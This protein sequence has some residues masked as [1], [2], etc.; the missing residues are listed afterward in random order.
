MKVVWSEEA[1]WALVALEAR[2]AR[3]YSADRAARIVEAL[4]RRV[5]LLEDHPQLGRVVPEYGEWQLRE[6]VDRWNRVLYR[7]TPEPGHLGALVGGERIALLG[8]N[9][10]RSPPRCSVLQLTA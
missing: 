5:R 7:L 2:L 1:A 6:L 9:G 10:S 8:A 3:R 4:V